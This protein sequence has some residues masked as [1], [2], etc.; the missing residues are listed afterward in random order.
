MKSEKLETNFRRLLSDDVSVSS[1]P[2]LNRSVEYRQWNRPYGSG[3]KL[4]N[5]IVLGAGRSAASF[6]SSRVAIPVGG[7]SSVPVAEDAG[8]ELA[9]LHV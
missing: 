4:A 7:H 6:L 8:N 5:T 9:F 2:D 1:V 3:G